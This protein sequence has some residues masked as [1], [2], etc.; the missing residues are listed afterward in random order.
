MRDFFISYSSSDSA[1]AEWLAWTIEAAGY[2]VMLQAWDFEPGS[3]F[4]LEMDRALRESR[5]TVAVLSPNYLKSPYARSEWAAVLRNDPE[6]RARKLVPVRVAECEVDG[7]LGAIVYV[8]LVGVEKEMARKQ[9]LAAIYGERRKPRSEPAFPEE[10]LEMRLAAAKSFGI[11]R[12]DE[13][14]NPVVMNIIRAADLVP[15]EAHLHL[16]VQGEEQSNMVIQ[17]MESPLRAAQLDPKYCLE[18]GTAVLNFG[19]TLPRGTP[20]DVTIRLLTDG[21]LE[22]EAWHSPTGN[23]VS[24]RFRTDAVVEY[25]ENSTDGKP[26]WIKERITHR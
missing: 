10:C 22:L 3:H 17:F 21:I 1:W 7:L 20:V 16:I 9:L 6:G 15:Q 25:C 24:C 8:D 12:W 23:S 19:T 14:A 13:A 4:I 5:R 26:E 2:S 18:L 11:L